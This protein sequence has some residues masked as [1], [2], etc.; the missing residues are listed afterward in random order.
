MGQGD[1]HISY[2]FHIYCK[3]PWRTWAVTE[4]LFKQMLGEYGWMVITGFIMMIFKGVIVN[5][6]EALMI[7][8]GSDYDSDMVVYIG[9]DEKPARIVRVGLTKTIF[10]MKQGGDWSIKLVVPNE[11]LKSMVIKQKLPSNGHI[12]TEK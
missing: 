11:R 1:W 7:F 12:I 2:Y 10:Y 6:F 3:F 4:E 8:I 5:T 9:A